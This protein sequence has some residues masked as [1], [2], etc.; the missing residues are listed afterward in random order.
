MEN[1][2]IVPHNYKIDKEK[3][4]ENLN[5]NPVIIWFTGLSGSGKSTLANIIEQQ[6]YKKG[7]KTYLLDGDNVRMGLNKYL[8][9]S[10]E[11]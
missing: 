7:Y 8:G 5:Q 6:L 4:K 2:N 9:F 11:Y 10:D 1:R 3:R